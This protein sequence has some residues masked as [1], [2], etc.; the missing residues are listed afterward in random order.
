MKKVFLLMLLALAFCVQMNAQ[1]YDTIWGRNPN[2]YYSEWYDTCPGYFHPWTHCS[3]PNG[4]DSVYGSGLCKNY[5]D[6]MSNMK[7]G[8]SFHTD[9][10]LW[11]KGLAA[12]VEKD[13]T[14]YYRQNETRLPEYLYLYQYTTLLQFKDSIRWDTVAPKI[15]LF[16]KLIDTTTFGCYESYV[17]EN[18][19]KEPI[20]VDSTFYIAGTFNSNIG[21]RAT[22]PY[23]PTEYIW[24]QWRHWEQECSYSRKLIEYYPNAIGGHPDFGQGWLPED[25]EMTHLPGIGAFLAIIDP[26]RLV[27]GLPADTAHG[28]VVGGG[29]YRDSTFAI[30]AAHGYAGH[31]FSHWSDGDTTNPRQVFVLSDTTF[32]AY[33]DS[34]QLFHLDVSS[35]NPEWGLVHGS[36]AYYEGDVAT[37][38]AEPWNWDCHFVRWSDG[39]TDNPRQVVVTQDSSI[40]AIFT[41]DTVGIET[42]PE[43]RGLRLSPN[44]A[45]GRIEIAVERADHYTATIYTVTGALWLREE[46]DGKA[47]SVDI[48]VLTPGTYLLRLEAK[49]FS[50]SE[51]FIKGK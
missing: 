17:F 23:I 10:P 2:Y 34:L 28:F 49:G 50:A 19:F 5:I 36:G 31:I 15:A 42:V 7:W 22:S 39:V 29:Y 38:S 30:L 33:F 27:K 6:Q 20:L 48:S 3:G 35:N 26:L 11:I 4:P 25:P 9:R 18:Y 13:P 43:R 46:F 44:P 41:N 40:V 1:Q 37:I 24:F 8:L 16:P 47:A 14:G 51:T 32:T 12:L 45:S 21:D